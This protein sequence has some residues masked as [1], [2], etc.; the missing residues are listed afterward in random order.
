MRKKFIGRQGDVL[1]FKIEEKGEKYNMKKGKPIL[2]YGE[3]HGHKHQIIEEIPYSILPDVND[4]GL[5]G[6]MEIEE[7][8]TLTLRHGTD[9]T[10]KHAKIVIEEPGLYGW[11]IQR[12]WHEGKEMKV[13]D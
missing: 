9:T 6:L 11:R 13:R 7:G 5:E 10:E 1:L 3:T 4:Y 12:E 2:A 8:K